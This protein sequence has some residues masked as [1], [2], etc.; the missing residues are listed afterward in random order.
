MT[1]SPALVE[2]ALRAWRPAT[3]LR[4]GDAGHTVALALYHALVDALPSAVRPLTSV[5]LQSLDDLAQRVTVTIA[6]LGDPVIVLSPVALA[7]DVTHM[8]TLA[9]EWVHVGQIARAGRVQSAVDYLG[10]GELRAQREADA[11][12]AGLWMR[13]VLTGDLPETAPSLSE[14]YHLD[15][16]DAALARAIISSHLASTRAGVL[17]PLDVCVVLARLVAAEGDAA[18]RARLP[19][20]IT[21]TESHQ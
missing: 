16:G 11:Y 7:D 6:T 5:A 15:A 14:L 1:L 20:A 19:R 21:S 2:T 18:Q 8:A 3:T 13:Y 12:A 10:S 17:P 9:H 4:P